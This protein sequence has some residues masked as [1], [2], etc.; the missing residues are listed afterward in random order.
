MVG[1]I[2]EEDLDDIGRRLEVVLM[3]VLGHLVADAVELLDVMLVVGVVDDDF[4]AGDMALAPHAEDAHAEVNVGVEVEHGGVVVGFVGDECCCGGE[5]RCG[6][7]FSKPDGPHSSTRHTEAGVV[8]DVEDDIYD[9]RDYDGHAEAS[10]ADNGA[11][12][13][14]DEEEDDARQSQYEFVD[15]FYL[16]QPQVSVS[17]AC[18]HALEV[19]LAHVLVHLRKGI[20]HGHTLLVG[21]QFAV[22]A[23]EVVFLP[24][25]GLKGAQRVGLRGAL[26]GIGEFLGVGIV[27]APDAVVGV[28]E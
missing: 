3:G 15:G 28:V 8:E 18:H 7:A 13:R 27:G 6:D 16:V 12:W 4:L 17:F 22:D 25:G 5:H 24:A 23:V 21:R 14:A 10:S 9:D 2:F 1:L 19:E 26:Y 20:V 11:E